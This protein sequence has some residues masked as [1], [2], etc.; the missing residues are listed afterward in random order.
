MDSWGR[1]GFQRGVRL[2]RKAVVAISIVTLVTLL[3]LLLVASVT[4]VRRQMIYN[5]NTYPGILLGF[6]L[7]WIEQGLAGLED[8]VK[9]FVVCG[10]LMLLCFML[11]GLGGGR[12]EA[13]RDDGCVPG[14]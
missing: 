12:C 6:G 9:G 5:W 11:F 2:R 3:L 13:D 14:L 4:D 10:V 7:K 1:C 8:S